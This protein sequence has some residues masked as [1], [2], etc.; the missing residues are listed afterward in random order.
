MNL[1]RKK[2]SPMM[3]TSVHAKSKKETFQV[4][5]GKTPGA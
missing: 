1:T 5:P 3:E 4:A 2:N